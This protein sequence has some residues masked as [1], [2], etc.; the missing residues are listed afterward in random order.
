MNKLIK[1]PKVYLVD[2][3]ESLNKIEEYLFDID[4]ADFLENELLQ[5]AVIRRLEVVGEAVRRLGE[6]FRESNSSLPWKKMAGIRDV[7]IHGYDVVDLG[8][9]W[10]LVA[11]DELKETKAKL[12]TIL[13]GLE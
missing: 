9:V 7:L 11:G 6:D 3:L 12:E 2:I 13:G 10:R 1:S 8:L 4:E 5:D